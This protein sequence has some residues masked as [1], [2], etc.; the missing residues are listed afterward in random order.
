MELESRDYIII[1]LICAFIYLKYENSCNKNSIEKM[2]NTDDDKITEVIN[3]I[4]KADVQSIRNLAEISEKLQKGTLSIP[5]NLSVEGIMSVEGTMSVEGKFNY[6]PTGSIIAFKGTTAPKGWVVCDGRNGT[7]NLK[8]RF[9]YGYDATKGIGSVG[10]AATVRLTA[11]QMPAHSH[12]YVDSYFAEY[13]GVNKGYYGSNSGADRDNAPYSVNK[14][15]SVYGGGQP[16]EN[17]PPYCVL[18]YI[19]KL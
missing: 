8:G 1:I 13:Q 6:L 18:L 4:Y 5:G 2:S 14:N 17:M 7:P 11:A 12:P 16:H 15:T 19:M 10:G 9:I 3:K